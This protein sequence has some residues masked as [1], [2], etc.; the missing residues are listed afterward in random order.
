M[1]RH[2]I[3]KIRLTCYISVQKNVYVYVTQRFTSLIQGKSFMFP[4]PGFNIFVVWL[5]ASNAQ[6][7]ST[8]CYSQVVVIN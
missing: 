3:Y 8:V 1:Q 4:D 2:Q 5:Y 6:L 7:R